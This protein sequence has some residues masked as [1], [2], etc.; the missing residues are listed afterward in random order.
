VEG[1]RRKRKKGDVRRRRRERDGETGGVER[2][3]K[4]CFIG[5]VGGR[6]C[7]SLQCDVS[8]TVLGS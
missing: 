5:Y 7:T 8:R 4:V 3:G 2:R 1:K 6:P